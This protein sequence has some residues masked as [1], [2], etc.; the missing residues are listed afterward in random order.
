M[1]NNLQKALFIAVGSTIKKH[2]LADACHM[3]FYLLNFKKAERHR[4]NFLQ[5]TQLI[6]YNIEF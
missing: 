1:I 2:C 3:P 4:I 6:R 5:K